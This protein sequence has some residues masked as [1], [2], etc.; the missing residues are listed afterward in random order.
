MVN[1]SGKWPMA[2]NGYTWFSWSMVQMAN[3]WSVDVMMKHWH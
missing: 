2:I 1:A 3:Q